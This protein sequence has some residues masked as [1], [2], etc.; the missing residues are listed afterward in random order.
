MAGDNPTGCFVETTGTGVIKDRH[1]IGPIVPAAIRA[2]DRLSVARLI[3]ADRGSLKPLKRLLQQANVG[4]IHEAGW[5]LESCSIRREKS[6]RRDLTD[7]SR[8]L[9]CC[10]E[11]AW[12]GLVIR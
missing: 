11:D 5:S 8:S 3:P 12:A 9:S 6:D 4:G 1:G 7:S 2:A 10:S